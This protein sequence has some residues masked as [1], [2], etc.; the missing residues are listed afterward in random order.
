MMSE[1]YTR[2]DIEGLL[3]TLMPDADVF[4]YGTGPDEKRLGLAEIK[5]QAERDWSQTEAASF[6]LDWYIV[7][8]A[9]TVA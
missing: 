2:R 1:A 9:G 3:T 8:T 7:S 5:A 6:D 4:L